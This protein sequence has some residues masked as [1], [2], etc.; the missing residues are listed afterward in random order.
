MSPR[1]LPTC[2]RSRPAASEPFKRLDVSDESDVAEVEAW[3]KHA[4]ELEKPALELQSAP[5]AAE[6][7]GSDDPVAGD[8]ERKRVTAHQRPHVARIVDSG[9]AAE[10]TVGHGYAERRRLAEDL[11]Q[12]AMLGA[13]VRPVELE[14]ELL[15]PPPRYSVSCAAASR[16]TD[17]DVALPSADATRPSPGS[18]TRR[19]PSSLASTPSVPSEVVS[20]I[21]VVVLGVDIEPA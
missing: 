8:D 20:A 5:V 9:T 4:F 6:P 13:D 14:L 3:R 1:P 17:A 2:E 10:L 12:M 18:R 15:R 21:A 16:A 11:Q 19:S 7:V